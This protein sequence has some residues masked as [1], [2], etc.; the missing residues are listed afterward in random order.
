[1]KFKL[2]DKVLMQILVKW[3]CH[4]RFLSLLLIHSDVLLL[5][6][7]SFKKNTFVHKACLFPYSEISHAV[8]KISFTTKMGFIFILKIS[9]NQQQPLKPTEKEITFAWQSQG[10]MF[11]FTWLTNSCIFSLLWIS[12]SIIYDVR[13]KKL[14][15]V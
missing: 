13:L 6:A 4:P 3:H 12:H 7:P 1:M 2:T 15:K 11:W 8:S 9:I 14:L 5:Y 10:E